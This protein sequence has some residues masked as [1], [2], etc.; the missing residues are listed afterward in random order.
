M[1]ESQFDWPATTR[2]QDGH[3]RVVQLAHLAAITVKDEVVHQVD[4]AQD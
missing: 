1:T 3:L 4:Q 2:K